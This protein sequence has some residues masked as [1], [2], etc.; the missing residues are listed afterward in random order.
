MQCISLLKKLKIQA[1]VLKTVYKGDM[2]LTTFLSHFLC[3]FFLSPFPKG[4]VLMYKSG[5]KQS[6]SFKILNHSF[7]IYSNWDSKSFLLYF[8]ILQVSKKKCHINIYTGQNLTDIWLSYKQQT[9]DRVSVYWI[10]WTEIIN[11]LTAYFEE[12]W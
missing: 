11:T 7:Y 3:F 10:Y 6:L 5:F 9:L 8:E 4:L 2:S 12:L 1:F